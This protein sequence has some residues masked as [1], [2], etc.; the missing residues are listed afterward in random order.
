MTQVGEEV[1]TEEYIMYS[2]RKGV[3]EEFKKTL[4]RVNGGGGGG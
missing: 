2:S 3:G 1:K 4:F